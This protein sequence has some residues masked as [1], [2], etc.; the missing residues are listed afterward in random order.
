V[1]LARTRS[2]DYLFDEFVVEG[3]VVDD[4]LLEVLPAAAGG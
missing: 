4:V 2:L 3:V 1:A